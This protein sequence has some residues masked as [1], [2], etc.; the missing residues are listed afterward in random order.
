[1]SRVAFQVRTP[2]DYIERRWER[3]FHS[4]ETT[5]STYSRFYMPVRVINF[6]EGG[7][8][9]SAEGP[10]ARGEEVKIELVDVG[11]VTGRIAWSFNGRV[12]G[13]FDQPINTKT[14]TEA[15]ESKQTVAPVTNS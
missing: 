9:L 6:S 14:L 8:L 12:G 1:V 11:E 15:L 2:L 10:L 5:L 7:F 13:S 3:I 4:F